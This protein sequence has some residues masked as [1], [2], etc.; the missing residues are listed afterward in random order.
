VWFIAD[1]GAFNGQTDRTLLCGLV[2]LEENLVFSRRALLVTDFNREEI[3][4]A[5]MEAFSLG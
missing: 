3:A 1:I 4:N 5:G 2:G